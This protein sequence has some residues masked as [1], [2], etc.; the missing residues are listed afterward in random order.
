[1]QGK[2]DFSKL[3]KK[4]F[5]CI[6]NISKRQF[7]NKPFKKRSFSAMINNSFLNNNY[8]NSVNN[9]GLKLNSFFHVKNS[10]SNCNEKSSNEKKSKILLEN[11][12]E[13]KMINFQNI[14]IS[15]EFFKRLLEDK[16]RSYCVNKI[17]KKIGFSLDFYK[18]LNKTIE[19][20]K[21][22][23]TNEKSF[24]YQ[25]GLENNNLVDKIKRKLKRKVKRN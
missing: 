22:I 11:K 18:K 21:N 20:Q 13:S 7:E 8:T 15:K 12:I 25:K 4:Q 1:M 16:K 9:K 19:I 14:K 23:S 2:N 24:S 17:N 6:E 5:F 10:Q 3:I